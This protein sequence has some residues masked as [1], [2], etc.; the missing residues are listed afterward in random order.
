V[1]R[2]G[3]G[4][5]QGS[6][7]EGYGSCANPDYQAAGLASAQDIV[8]SARFLQSQAYVD[9]GRLLLV[10]TS[11]GGF[12]ALASASLAPPGLVGVSNFAGGRGSPSTDSVCREDRLIAAVAHYGKSV[13]VPTLWVY[14]E[15]DHFFGPSLA[16]AMFDAFTAA[17]APSSRVADASHGFRAA[18]ARPMPLPTPSTDVSRPASRARPTPSMTRWPNQCGKPAQSDARLIL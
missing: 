6:F 18:A 9:P 12:G 14:A 4:G 15:N 16:R 11:A 13:R 2:R 17:G 7:A 3:Y 1:A 10:G 8:Q 5:S